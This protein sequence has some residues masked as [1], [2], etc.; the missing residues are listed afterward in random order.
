MF[1]L[2]L[3]EGRI[4]VRNGWTFAAGYF[5][6]TH[7]IIIDSTLPWWWKVADLV[8]ETFHYLNHIVLDLVFLDLVWDVL[9]LVITFRW[10]EFQTVCSYYAENW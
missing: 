6:N 7:T 2:E 1:K 8:H 5:G 3:S 10:H 4:A 9:C